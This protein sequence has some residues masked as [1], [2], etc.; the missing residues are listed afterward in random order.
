MADVRL[1][2]SCLGVPIDHRLEPLLGTRLATPDPFVSPGGHARAIESYGRCLQNNGEDI[3]DKEAKFAKWLAMPETKGGVVIVLQ[4]PAEHQRYFSDHHQT[5]KDCDTLDAVDEEELNEAYAIFLEMIQQKQPDVVFCCYRSPHSTKY[6]GFQCIGIG[7]TRDYRV[8]VQGQRYT[9]VNG[10]HPSYALNYLEDKSALRSLFI[11]EAMQA[12]RRAN[13]TWKRSPW[14]TDVR[15]NCTAIVRKDIEDKQD[16]PR[17]TK[18]DFQRERFQ[19]YMDYV[20]RMLDSLKSGAYDD[21]TNDDL[22]DLILKER[23]NV[24][25][26]NCLLI[27]VK[28]IK[29]LDRGGDRLQDKGFEQLRQR[30][31]RDIRDLRRNVEKRCNEFLRSLRAARAP[32]QVERGGKGLFTSAGLN[33]SL[34]R[35]GP[36]KHQSGFQ[37]NLRLSFLS[38]VRILNGAYT[39]QG[40]MVYDI[41]RNELARAF[42]LAAGHLEW[43]M[44]QHAG[45]TRRRA[46]EEDL[47]IS[48]RF[49]LL[50]IGGSPQTD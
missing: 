11:I 27:L 26:P 18:H 33:K 28:I 35:L 48:S 44:A 34:L 3:S 25:F 8:T 47:A 19:I 4:Q 37:Y 38:L 46:S 14:M 45:S 20:T 40:R 32:F 10:F 50:T 43:G 2:G 13:G 16:Q 24:L 36:F 39:C 7:R 6:K 5:V 12:F 41:D 15:E 49:N 9:C 21:M 30:E 31:E 42:R 1:P 23:Y 17:W 22:Y 29:F